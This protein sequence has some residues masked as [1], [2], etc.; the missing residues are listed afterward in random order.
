MKL[1]APPDVYGDDYRAEQWRL[2]CAVPYK[3]VSMKK[4]P[5]AN[6]EDLG[7]RK[8]REEPASMKRTRKLL[9]GIGA[10]QLRFV[11]VLT[12]LIIL[13]ILVWAAYL[14]FP[15]YR[16]LGPAGNGAPTEQSPR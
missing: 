2:T 11:D 9:S 7:N 5:G 16:Q 15:V 10:T 8:P 3:P 14:Q 4:L 13:G 12:A 6:G 1:K